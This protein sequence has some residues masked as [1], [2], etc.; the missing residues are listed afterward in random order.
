MNALP[1]PDLSLFDTGTNDVE[2]CGV[3]VRRTDGSTY[4]IEVPNRSETP[5]HHFVVSTKDVKAVIVPEGDVIVGIVHTHPFRAMR[6]A[7]DH[8]IDSI[9]DGLIG[10]VYH[11]STRSVVWYDSTGTIEQRLRKRR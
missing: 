10:M 1:E 8:D 6:I 7:S 11:P 9:P 5:K 2:R 3:I 4:V